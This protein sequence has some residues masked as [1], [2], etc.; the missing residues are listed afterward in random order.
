[1]SKMFKFNKAIR[2]SDGTLL[3]NDNPK[4]GALGGICFF[5]KEE[6]NEIQNAVRAQIAEEEKAKQPKEETKSKSAKK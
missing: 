3:G 4:N 2:L 5:D 1:M 6:D